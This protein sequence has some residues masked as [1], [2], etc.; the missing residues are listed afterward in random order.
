MT[1]PVGSSS[2][3]VTCACICSST[4]SSHGLLVRQL[5]RQRLSIPCFGSHLYHDPLAVAN[6][7]P[8]PEY[9]SLPSASQ[10]AT[11][12]ADAR[13]DEDH[14]WRL[15]HRATVAESAVASINQFLDRQL[16]E[17]IAVARTTALNAL[18]P[19]VTDILKK[20]LARDAIASAQDNLEDL[21]ALQADDEFDESRPPSQSG[22]K[23]NLDFTWKRSR[24]RVM[25]RSEKSEFDID[26]DERYVRQEG[27]NTTF[28]ETAGV[29]SLA[30][31]I[32]LAGVLDYLG[33]MLL[34][35]AS[36]V[37]L[38]RIQ[39][40]NAN[41]SLPEN[42][43]HVTYILVDDADLER[44]VLN[45]PLDRQW[46][47]WKKSVRLH[48][49]A[50]QQSHSVASS[51][52]V[53][54]RGS[55]WDRVPDRPENNYPEHVLASNIP[56]PENRRDVDEIEV[57]GLARDPDRPQSAQQSHYAPRAYRPQSAGFTAHRQYQFDNFAKS[58]PVS[59]PLPMT[60]PL[61]EAP[62]AWP[63]DTPTVEILDPTSQF[64]E[65]QAG[66]GLPSV[67]VDHSERPE[68]RDSAHTGKASILS[69]PTSLDETLPAMKVVQRPKRLAIYGPSSARFTQAF[70]LSQ[71]GLELAADLDRPFSPEDFLASRNLSG[72]HSGL[73]PTSSDSKP[74]ALGSPAELS[75]ETFMH[76][77]SGSDTENDSEPVIHTALSS[78]IIA[79]SPSVRQ[80]PGLGISRSGSDASSG[81]ARTPISEQRVSAEFV[82]TRRASK[83]ADSDSP[84]PG[85]RGVRQISRQSVDERKKL[86]TSSLTS[87]KDFDA[88][89]QR[90]ET[91]KYTLTPENVRDS[92]DR[93]F[94]PQTRGKKPTV[95]RS[96]TGDN[97]RK[98]SDTQSMRSNSATRSTPAV[99]QI[100]EPKPAEETRSRKT[101]ISRPSPQNL[102][103]LP[104]G[105]TAREAVMQTESTR[106]LADFFR[107]TAPDRE[108]N[109]VVPGLATSRSVTSMRATAQA[110]AASA[111]DAPPVPKPTTS[112]GKYIPRSPAGPPP[113]RL[114]NRPSL[115][116][117]AATGSSDNNG[118][119]IDFIR[120]GPPGPDGKA[121]VPTH[122]APFADWEGGDIHTTVTGA[123]SSNVNRPLT[124]STS[125]SR[126]GLLMNGT[127]NINYGSGSTLKLPM[128]P[129]PQPSSS[130]MNLVIPNTRPTV[131]GDGRTRSRIKDPYVI[132]DDSDDDE[133]DVLAALPAT[134]SNSN[135]VAG[136][137][138]PRAGSITSMHS[139]AGRSPAMGN[140]NTPSLS[141]NPGYAPSINSVR[142]ATSTNAVRPAHI[143]SQISS[144]NVPRSNRPKMEVR[145]AGVVRTARLDP[146][147]SSGT[148][149]LA[150]FLMSSG[151]PEPVQRPAPAPAV[152]KNGKPEKAEK[153]KSKFWQRSSSSK[154][155][156][157]DMP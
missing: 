105:Q 102:H 52:V 147:Q 24:L 151:P 133:E 51:P 12:V 150:D 56:L 22:A 82:K 57:P 47:A 6:V 75:A 129:L 37:T 98:N 50:S 60:T 91:I 46:R 115:T 138:K 119:L 155:T 40:A 9:I 144:G 61:V 149:D 25:M 34:T 35:M 146:F 28:S 80:F 112:N 104:S 78:P 116:A 134:N 64:A 45:S 8:A 71:E 36:Q 97:S 89:L 53:V 131:G 100:K 141:P 86:P 32:F 74:Q 88:L 67:N 76:S 55:L 152:G 101:S 109:P 23:F 58:R 31:E 130:A 44:A 41:L 145:S 107:S 121:R 120:G 54:R 114:A 11:D 140:G 142:S 124:S 42:S 20:N 43:D 15:H 143:T 110:Q 49:R 2:A 103:A 65:G 39:R 4:S 157:V 94:S 118:D 154:N 13:A 63:T 148:S 14:S 125:D 33:E 19:A 66:E 7:K 5:N 3:H 69:Q 30:S 72:S 48:N 77:D 122:I 99:N 108:P 79:T 135:T 62:G 92:S 128:S 29:I 111:R 18:K 95:F 136:A 113:K 117:R 87:E 83:L 38:S 139:S 90:D 93:A 70:H 126:T 106:D 127:S 68:S 59:V 85:T 1:A 123:Q 21:L 132:P 16:Y 26:D 10:L 84:S 17:Y 156:Y 73:T 96:N 137:E 81:R 153:K 27:L